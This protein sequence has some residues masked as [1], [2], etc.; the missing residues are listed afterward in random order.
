[1]RRMYAAIT[2]LFSD[3]LAYASDACVE[4]GRWA[5]AA[6]TREARLVTAGVASAVAVAVG[7]VLLIALL[8]PA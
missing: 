4:L 6:S 2:G 5:G 8:V 1:M 3:A 7:V